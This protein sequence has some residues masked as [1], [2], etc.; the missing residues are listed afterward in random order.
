MP[1]LTVTRDLFNPAVP[2]IA[3]PIWVQ[4]T[5]GGIL[6]AEDVV[7]LPVMRNANISHLRLSSTL[8]S[9]G[10][11]CALAVAKQ[12]LVYS[13]LNVSDSTGRHE[14]YVIT[15]NSILGNVCCERRQVI[16]RSG[17]PQAVDTPMP[18]HL[19]RDI[20]PQPHMCLYISKSSNQ[21][22]EHAVAITWN[23]GDSFAGQLR[24]AP[25]PVLHPS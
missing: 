25:C 14:A 16:K 4:R 8:D 3:S 6:G 21:G 19:T 1:I 7:V 22:V 5:G 17:A 2:P 10:P 13:N 24:D 18:Q 20:P 15:P 12:N 9:L 11:M 23:I